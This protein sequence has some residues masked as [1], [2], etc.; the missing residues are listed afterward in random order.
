MYFSGETKFEYFQ[1]QSV[2]YTGTVNLKV[3]AGGK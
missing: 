2:D 3:A 1:V